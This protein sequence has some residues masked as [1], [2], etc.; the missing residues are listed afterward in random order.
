LF[1]IGA[2]T[3]VYYATG[4]RFFFTKLGPCYPASQG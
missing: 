2:A 1:L 3:V 4:S